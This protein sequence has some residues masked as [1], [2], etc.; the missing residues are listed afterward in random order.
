VR[1]LAYRLLD[2]EFPR[3]RPPEVVAFAVGELPSRSPYAH[4]N[5]HAGNEV[6]AF[7]VGELPGCRDYA[8]VSCHTGY[9]VVAFAVGELPSCSPYAHFSIGT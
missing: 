2:G 9:E 5:W 4:V 7:A 1:Q 8:H 6:V 3:S